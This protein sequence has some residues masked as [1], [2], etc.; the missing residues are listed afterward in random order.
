LWQ[1]AR[2]RFAIQV[3][4]GH[5]VTKTH[6]ADEGHTT[7][8]CRGPAAKLIRF[9]SGHFAS[10]LPASQAEGAVFLLAG[11]SSANNPLATATPTAMAT[12]RCYDPNVP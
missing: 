12:A 2:K 5:A 8:R 4:T 3:G 11:N 9:E 6:S 7:G 10:A 1:G